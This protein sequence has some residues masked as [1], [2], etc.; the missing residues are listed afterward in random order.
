LN[1]S[2]K[3]IR[4]SIRCSQ[5]YEEFPS[6]FEYRLHW[7]TKHFY[8]YLKTNSFDSNKALEDARYNRNIDRLIKEISS[9]I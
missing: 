1:Y 9:N 7:E 6:G 4:N 5:C 3:K 8:P 2:I